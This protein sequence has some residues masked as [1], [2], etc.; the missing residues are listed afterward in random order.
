M[1]LFVI[2]G[3]SGGVRAARTAAA[4]GARVALAEERWLGG[5]CVNAGCIPKKILAYGTH[6]AHDLDDARGL[7]WTFSEARLDWRALRDAKDVEVRRLNGVYRTLLE[8]AGV[9]I[10]DARAALEGPGRVRVGAHTV[11]ARHVLVATG[12][13]PHRPGVP[14]VDL[15]WTSDDVFFLERLPSRVVVIGVG[16]VGLE[17]AAVLAGA[18]VEVEVLGRHEHVLMRFDP[19]VRSHV[20]SEMEKR[21]VRFAL[22]DPCVRI[23]RA[24]AGLIVAR[25]RGA[26]LRADAVLVATGR[27]PRTEGLGLEAAGVRL[28]HDGHVEVGEG[29]ETSAPGHFA[30]GD[31]VGRMQLTPVALAEGMALARSLYGGAGPVRVDYEDVPTAVFTSPPVA[32]V[33]L[34]EPEARGRGHDV[35]IFESDFRP[36]RAAASGATDRTLVKLV[37]DRPSDRVL[38]V[39]VV[40]EDAPEMVQG[41]AVALKCGATKARFDA[42]MGIHPTAAEELVTLRTPS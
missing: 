34:T 10:H 14:G 17:L 27:E 23:E 2:G 6:V 36:L 28:A 38:G 32:T 25:E 18:G 33:G 13:R 22:G 15:A 35:A 41:F 24:G 37:V 1:D 40:G 12:G 30:V 19:R 3:G 5:T 42:T 7:G 31:V 26:P 16:Y 21:G 11:R 39:H 29:F 8:K 4:L 9:E 20:Q